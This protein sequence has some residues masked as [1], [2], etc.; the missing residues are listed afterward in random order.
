MR[1]AVLADIHS[2]LR[3]LDAVVDD[4]ATRGVDEVVVGGDIV[5]RGPQGAAVVDRVRELGWPSVRG[6]HEDYLVAFSREELS[7]IHI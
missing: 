7:L 3:A 4:I 6:N 1:I 5:G 2:N